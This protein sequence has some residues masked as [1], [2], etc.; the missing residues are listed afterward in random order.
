MLTRTDIQFISVGCL[1]FICSINLVYSYNFRALVRRTIVSMAPDAS[2]CIGPWVSSANV[3]LNTLGKFAS[4]KVILIEKDHL[5]DWSP[6]KD[7]C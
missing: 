7:C 4:L 6:E 3:L 5:G 2:L 1:F